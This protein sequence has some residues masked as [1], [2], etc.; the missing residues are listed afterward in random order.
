MGNKATDGEF[1]LGGFLEEPASSLSER[2]SRGM[3][4][5]GVRYASSF[6]AAVP[7]RAEVAILFSR[8]ELSPVVVFSGEKSPDL[9]LY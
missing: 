2:T 6:V 4:M 8:G 5:R 1:C 3:I 7:R 9:I